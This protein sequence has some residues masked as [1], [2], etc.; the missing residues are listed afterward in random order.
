MTNTPNPQDNKTIDDIVLSIRRAESGMRDARNSGTVLH[1]ISKF[2]E[3]KQQ[4]QAL[5]AKARNKALDDVK[6]YGYG[7]DDG[8]GF[9]IKISYEQLNALKLTPKENK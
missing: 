2:D 6:F 5:I 8:T 3:A 1:F 9:V 7:Y 4:I